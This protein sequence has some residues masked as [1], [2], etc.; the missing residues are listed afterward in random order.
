V[1][2]ISEKLLPQSLIG[3]EPADRRR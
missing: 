3:R 2:W 1:M